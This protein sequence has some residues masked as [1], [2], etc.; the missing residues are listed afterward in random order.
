MV[1]SREGD[2]EQV[3][4]LELELQEKCRLLADLE[5]I[6]EDYRREKS[7]VLEEVMAL[8]EQLWDLTGQE[9]DTD[10]VSETSGD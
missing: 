1:A 7:K 8:K 9:R 4:E 3:G 10:E 2:A 6:I 5:V